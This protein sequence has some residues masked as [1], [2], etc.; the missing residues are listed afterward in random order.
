MSINHVRNFVAVTLAA[1]VLLLGTQIGAAENA[2]D[3]LDVLLM[4][5]ELREDSDTTF[6][7]LFDSAR[8]ERALSEE[9]S[10]DVGHNQK[11]F[12]HV[13][14]CQF[15]LGHYKDG[16]ATSEKWLSENKSAPA[17]SISFVYEFIGICHL[18][19]REYQQ[20]INAFTEAKKHFATRKVDS[21]LNDARSFLAIEEGKL[22]REEYEKKLL[23]NLRAR[24]PGIEASLKIASHI[25][26]YAPMIE[27][28]PSTIF[29][30]KGD[31]TAW[32]EAL[33]IAMAARKL[34]DR[35]EFGKASKLYKEAL[36]IYSSDSATWS[37]FALCMMMT[38]PDESD[39]ERTITEIEEALQKAVQLQPTDWRTWNNLGVYKFSKTNTEEAAVAFQR[40]IECKDIPQFQKQ[41]IEDN[42]RICKGTGAIKKYFDGMLIDKFK[43]L[44]SAPTGQKEEAPRFQHQF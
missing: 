39:A 10:G 25:G 40:A 21:A 12:F 32:A 5:F 3:T 9:L 41:A 7:R 23:V 31:S 35:S 42:L 29:P 37:A 8:Y 6:G 17:S 11:K 2:A 22:T 16:V 24:N 36:Q 43:K 34:D 13:I 1:S 15:L 30:G 27:S 4:N 14:L 44:K 33:K 38:S 19:S 18:N 26:G 20:A 28:T